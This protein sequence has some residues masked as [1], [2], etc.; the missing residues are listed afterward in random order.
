LTPL[1]TIY[2]RQAIDAVTA[3]FEGQPIGNNAFSV[4]LQTDAGLFRELGVGNELRITLDELLA[5][6][7]AVQERHGL[8]KSAALFDS[9]CGYPAALQPD[10]PEAVPHFSIEMETGTGKTYVYL[11]T[12]FELNRL[13]GFTKFVIVVPSI[14]IREGVLTSVQLMREHFA[15]LYN[16]AASDCFVYDSRQLGR[17]RQFATGNT[18][19]IMI[20]NIQSFVKD[21][22]ELADDGES[23]QSRRRGAANVINVEQDRLSGRR[24]IEFIQATRP[25]VI[26]DEP[27]SVEGDTREGMTKSHQAILRLSPLCT[28]R[29]SATHKNPYHLL[30][31]LGPVE[32]YD[33]RLVKRIEV[34]SVQTEDTANDAFVQLEKVDNRNGIKAKLKINVAGRNATVRQKSVTVK[35]GDQL[36]VKSN[37]RQEYD[38]W[39]VR[40]ICCEVGNEY[41]EFTNGRMVTL[42]QALGGM[43]DDVMRAQ[44]RETVE[45]HLQKEKV[46]KTRGLKV[47]SLFFI[48]RVSNYRIYNDDGSTSLG[49][50]GRWFE[51][52]YRELTAK[53]LYRGVIELA[54][55]QVHGGYFSKDKSKAGK[56]RF[57]DTSGKTQED[58]DTY[59]L[60]MRDKERL[61]SPEEPLRFIFS[62][63]ALREGWDNPNVF[64]ICT[65]NETKSADRKRQEIGR[66]LRLPVNKGGERV[67]DADVNILTVIANEA[68]ED[69]AR[70]LQ[71]EYE[72]DYGIQFGRVPKEAFSK[73]VVPAAPG[74]AAHPL[75]N[76]ASSRIWAHL[77]ARGYLN[78]DGELQAAFDPRQPG[79]TLDLPHEFADLRAPVTDILNRYVFKNRVLN[80][81]ERKVLGFRKRVFD[82]SGDF[83]ALW[84][85]I[86]QRT[87]YRVEFA[88][89]ELKRRAVERLREMPRIQPV[90]VQ[91]QRAE[92][93]VTQAGVEPVS[94]LQERQVDAQPFNWLPDI[95]GYLQNETELTRSTLVEILVASRRLDEFPIN[96]QAFITQTTKQLQRALWDLMLD[97]I[98]YEKVDGQFWEMRRLEPESEQELFRYLDRLYQVRNAD[99][100]LYDFVEFSS[101]VE[102]KFAEQLDLNPRVKFFLKLPSWF[103]VDTPIGTYNP[104][105][106][107]VYED[108]AKVYLV[109]ETKGSAD[110][111]ELREKERRKTDCGRKHFRALDVDFDVVSNVQAALRC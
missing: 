72:E 1:S 8:P 87:R 19:Q 89:D 92:I 82:E 48:D 37:N 65:L 77:E 69:F 74:V 98:R 30:Y 83:K 24:P 47:L 7:H 20:I 102:H 11:R 70:T 85:R 64:Q 107:I 56:G 94:L 111:D 17:V 41:V 95:L 4:A 40:D 49:K 43:T 109:R 62:H 39:I 33:L 38:G 22:Q 68:Y 10:A 16:N 59:A 75:G 84:Q 53:P 67:R 88:S 25:I 104:D 110:P 52:A 66:G 101:D 103:V 36:F 14:P 60:I 5:N 46:L 63:S 80:A 34:A 105:W 23:G 78:S 32:A 106:A 45:R 51:E 2:Q 42:G 15:A 97:G 96:P 12:I 29:Y 76:D 21:V 73:L 91:V 31:K 86:S 100:T 55:E 6:L 93:G 27:Q 13:Y 108:D 54:V 61:L 57:K 50:I 44:M 35:A 99:K 28:L 3:L 79:F 26:L 71:T 90:R 18:L 9:V 81:R 58:E